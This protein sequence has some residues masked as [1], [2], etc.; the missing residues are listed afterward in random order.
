MKLLMTI[1]EIGVNPSEFAKGRVVF[2]ISPLHPIKFNGFSQEG[3]TW[4]IQ[5][6]YTWTLLE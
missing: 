4:L 5:E 3:I 2:G 6:D 1:I